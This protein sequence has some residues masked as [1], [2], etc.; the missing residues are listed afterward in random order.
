MNI[1]MLTSTFPANRD[2]TM[3]HPFQ[4]DFIDY[5]EKRTIIM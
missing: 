2:D 3:Q 1:L 4:M 5:A